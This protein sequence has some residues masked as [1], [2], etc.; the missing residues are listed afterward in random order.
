MVI[1]TR[2]L[3]TVPADYKSAG[4]DLPWLLFCMLVTVTYSISNRLK[5]KKV[6]PGQ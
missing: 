4:G 2:S 5:K 1:K 3:Q 6:S